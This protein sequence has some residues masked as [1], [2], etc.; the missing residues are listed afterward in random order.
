MSLLLSFSSKPI[1]PHWISLCLLHLYYTLLWADWRLS[2]RGKRFLSLAEPPPPK[3]S[4]CIS[5][6]WF[7]LVQCS[8]E[9]CSVQAMSCTGS[10]EL[11]QLY[12][13]SQHTTQTENRTQK[14]SLPFCT[15]L[16]GRAGRNGVHPISCLSGKSRHTPF[17]FIILTT[18]LSCWLSIQLCPWL[19]STWH[20]IC[21][22]KT[23]QETP[24]RIS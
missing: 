16:T 19:W 17:L 8:H 10:P 12:H 2:W 20:W 14:A 13:S 11:I 6:A 3:T 5:R 1:P 23:K 7:A 22:L 15:R 4:C 18:F 9:T 24:T 21:T